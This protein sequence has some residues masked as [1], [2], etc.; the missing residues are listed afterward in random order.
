MQSLAN[1]LNTAAKESKNGFN[2]LLRERW[3]AMLA[4]M[5]RASLQDQVLIL[6]ALG[7]RIS[8]MKPGAKDLLRHNILHEILDTIADRILKASSLHKAEFK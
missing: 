8:K 6:S 7:Q 5:D 2:N 4:N 1:E 3:P